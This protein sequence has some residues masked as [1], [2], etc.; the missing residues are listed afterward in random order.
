[1]QNY[2]PTNITPA[3]WDKI[4]PIVLEVTTDLITKTGHH[5]ETNVTSHI[6]QYINWATS[7]AGYPLDKSI[8]FHRDSIE[9]YIQ[10]GCPQ[11]SKKTRGS[12][13]SMLLRAAESTLPY[14][15]R[16]SRLKS[17]G[18][19]L[20]L[21]PY[22]AKDIGD[23]LSWANDQ[24]TE[25]KRVTCRGIL[26]LGLGA[27]LATT[28]AL[29][30]K[31]EDVLVD[32]HGVLV[33]VT[34]PGRE[35]IVPPFFFWEQYLVDLKEYSRNSEF[36][37]GALR[38]N[39]GQKNWLNSFISRCDLPGYQRPNMARMRN[40]WIFEHML[41]GTRL[42]NLNVVAGLETFRTIEKLL[43]Y[44]PE[45]SLDEIRREIKDPS[46]VREATKAYLAQAS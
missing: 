34:K 33:E 17:M 29:E 43:E 19:P 32:E 44:T 25:Y 13:R 38:V 5:K 18:D 28:D 12:R 45:P 22:S 10:N 11:L 6:T 2:R 42:R 3:Q 9:D 14:T 37:I 26:A 41:N 20:A 8:L 23:L 7:I 15:E 30:M 39:K 40:T 31:P 35:R 1:M 16:V 46:Y 27:G 4:R 24:P 36:L 21:K